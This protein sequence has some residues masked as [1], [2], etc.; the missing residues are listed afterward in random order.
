MDEQFEKTGT[1]D[2]YYNPKG[3]KK[4]NYFIWLVKQLKGWPIQNYLLWFFS[5]GFQLA[6][7]V[8]FGRLVIGD[9]IIIY[10]DYI[11]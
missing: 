7:Y 4:E 2:G 11:E 6:L 8:Y 1:Q 9:Y 10:D 5:F 3:S